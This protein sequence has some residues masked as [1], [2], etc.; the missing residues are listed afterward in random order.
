M[1]ATPRTTPPINAAIAGE[2]QGPCCL[3]ELRAGCAGC[4]TS[5]GGDRDLRRRL[6]EM[7]F[8]NGAKVEMLRRA[9][10]G[11]PIEFSLRGYCVSLRS[12]QARHVKLWV[13]EARNV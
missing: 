1:P 13:S 7:G 3:H 8:C 4:V 5:V 11:D 9:P 10:L 6:L 2:T 12:E